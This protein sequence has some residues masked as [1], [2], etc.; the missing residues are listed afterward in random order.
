MKKT[1]TSN[2]IVVCILTLT[3]LLLIGNEMLYAHGLLSKETESGKIRFSHDDGTPVAGGFIN[4]YDKE[5]NEM[6]TG[7]TDADGVFDYSGHE[8]AAKISI[9][10]A[11]GHHQAHVIGEAS[12]DH[13]AEHCDH[14]HDHAHDN[15]HSHEPSHSEG[16]NVNVIIAV[17]VILLAVAA[18]F[19]LRNKKNNDTPPQ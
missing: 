18:L 14:D 16:S 8:N 9:A 11:H 17:V 6:A 19:S 2:R 5:G 7:K 1:Q 12:H 4:V 10:D 3:A 13:S 15:G